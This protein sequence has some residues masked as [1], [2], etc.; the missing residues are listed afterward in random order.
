MEKPLLI[1]YFVITK[2][3]LLRSKKGERMLLYINDIK[4]GKTTLLRSKCF[5]YDRYV[6]IFGRV[7]ERMNIPQ[8]LKSKLRQ[9]EF[10]SSILWI[11]KK[12]KYFYHGLFA[13]EESYDDWYVQIK[14]I[15]CMFISTE[16]RMLLQ[17]KTL[18]RLQSRLFGDSFLFRLDISFGED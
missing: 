8:K 16:W 7:I 4:S 15:I 6:R 10:S 17:P 13:T 11:K 3:I 9:S 1:N 14:M 5:E 18:N 12:S 2:I